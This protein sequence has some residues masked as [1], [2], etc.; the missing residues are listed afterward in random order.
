MTQRYPGIKKPSWLKVEARFDVNYRR[1]KKLLV[2]SELRTVCQEA[3]CPNIS[4]CFSQKTATF[5]ILGRI[6]T[7]TCRFCDV[8]KGI[9]KALDSD[10]PQR[11]SE[12]V[13]KLGLE[14]VV[15]TS[16]TRDDLKDG[17]ASLFAQTITQ[18]KEK[19]PKIKVEVLIPDFKGSLESLNVVIQSAPAVLNHNLE[20]VQR[21]YP[22]V[23]PEADY[24]RSLEV[25]YNAKRF[26]RTIV[27]KSGLMIG[28]GEDWEE[29]IQAMRDLRKVDCDLLTMGQYLRPPSSSFEVR[30]YYHP[31]EFRKLK[32][33]GKNLGFKNVESAPLVRSSY[34]A[35]RQLEKIL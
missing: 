17:G 22:D 10:E 24:R 33:V 6:C 11:V 35:K 23:R 2:Q 18:I 3:R 9:P 26:N 14:Y 21:F 12:L 8:E 28:L 1:M 31:D 16:V 29:I 4:Q 27:T 25:L 5:M 20:T 7:R 19:N 13:K 32:I 34:H 15:I 30:K